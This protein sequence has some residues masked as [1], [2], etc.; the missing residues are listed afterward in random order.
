MIIASSFKSL[1]ESVIN[2]FKIEK[3]LLLNLHHLLLIKAA[4][5]M[6]VR[7]KVVLIAI[8]IALKK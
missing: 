3:Y 6:L 1:C 4:I 5:V 2:I 7:A 8:T